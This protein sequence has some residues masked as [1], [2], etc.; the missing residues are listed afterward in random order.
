MV[1]LDKP[2]QPLPIP[3]RFQPVRRRVVRRQSPTHLQL[4]AVQMRQEAVLQQVHDMCRE[5][6]EWDCLLPDRPDADTDEENP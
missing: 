2:G 4:T 6:G 5:P 3:P 1:S